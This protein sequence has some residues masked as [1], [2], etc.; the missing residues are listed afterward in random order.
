[1]TRKE[2]AKRQRELLRAF[3]KELFSYTGQLAWF[4]PALFSFLLLI[5]LFIPV[6]ETMDDMTLAI[7]VPTYFTLMIAYFVLHPYI[8]IQDSASANKKVQPTHLKL[9]YLPVSKRQ[10]RIVRMG[11]L[12]R[13]FWKLGLAGTIIQCGMALLTHTFGIANILYCIAIFGVLPMLVGL[14]TNYG[15][16]R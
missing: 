6:Q 7:W 3:D 4:I 10:Y 14:T 9:R 1:M 11:Y 13:F 16:S 5:Y 15:N 12:F 8:L 2:E